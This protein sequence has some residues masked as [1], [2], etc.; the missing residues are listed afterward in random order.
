L[1]SLDACV[2]SNLD[3][4]NKPTLTHC[5]RVCRSQRSMKQF[6][7]EQKHEILLEYSPRS[8]T[9]NFAALAHRHAVAGGGRTIRN[10]FARWDGSV[11][12][13]QHAKGA[14]RP[15][16]LTAEEVQRHIIAPIR[17]KNRAHQ[18][19][20]YSELQPV[21]EQET[22]KKV[23]SRTIRRYGKEEAGGRLKHGKKRTAEERAS[24]Q[25]TCSL[26]VRSCVELRPLTCSI[27]ALLFSVSADMC[28]QIAKVR[29][30][31]QR[32]GTRRILVLDETH[33]RIGDVTDRTIVLPGEPS[34]IETSATSHYAPRYDMIACCTSKEVLP[35]M[36][37]SPKERGK[38]VDTE[39]LLQYIRNL[40]AQSAGA[41][42]RYPL[43]LL[44]DKA[45]IH[46]ETK[47]IETFHDWGCQELVEVIKLPTAAA[48]RLSPLDNSL[49]NVFRQRV[50]HGPPLTRSNIKQ[51]MSDAWNS[52]T[53]RDLLPQ[54]RHCGLMRRQ[55]VYFDCP[56][57]AVHRH[58]S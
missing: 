11:A 49:F 53:E 41:L 3:A 22:G 24:V 36:I 30:K 55:D 14:G 42:D 31:F 48:K 58:G 40:L 45:T 50:L 56:N 44:L 4:Q 38:G 12:S 29:R 13:L 10:W 32:I 15:R 5:F 20:L 26:Q 35:P 46:N 16:S 34:T 1:S 28:E 8:T 9:H 2:C 51:R 19:I 6:T 43:L 33:R 54:Y 57:P 39:M 52:I 37:Y 27:S 25:H 17:R 18:P 21:V 23:S 7:P 47:I